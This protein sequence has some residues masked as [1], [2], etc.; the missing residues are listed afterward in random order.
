MT[1][2][3]TEEISFSTF[4][5]FLL[6]FLALISVSAPSFFSKIKFF[7]SIEPA[8]GSI[9]I[10]LCIGII[11]FFIL[12]YF[13]TELKP[14]SIRSTAAIFGLISAHVGVYHLIDRIPSIEI[15]GLFIFLFYF[16]FKE[17]VELRENTEKDE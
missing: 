15:Y 3:K 6:F 9:L 16:H 8:L 2:M 11:M 1:D 10:G 12:S 17:G 5:S 4:K 13:F 7:R 14:Q